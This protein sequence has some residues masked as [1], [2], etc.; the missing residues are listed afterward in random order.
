[1]CSVMNG[2]K[3][4]MA[5]VKVK[6]TVNRVLSAAVVSS[7][8]RLAVPLSRWRLSRMYQLLKFSKDF[9]KRG[10]TVYKR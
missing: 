1:M 6:S 8:P 3:G 4:A 5:Q 2:A 10:T 9:N 7:V